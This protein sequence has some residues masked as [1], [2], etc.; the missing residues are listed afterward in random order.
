MEFNNSM[1][2]DSNVGSEENNIQS[3]Q[4]ID[5][6]NSHEFDSIMQLENMMQLESI[7]FDNNRDSDD[8]VESDRSRVSASPYPNY[9]API[10]FLQSHISKVLKDAGV[11]C[12]LWDE[13]AFAIYCL[14]Q[15]TAKTLSWVIPD[16]YIHDA[17]A[18]LLLAKFQYPLELFYDDFVMVPDY[19]LEIPRKME[20][21][22]RPE[23]LLYQKTR[24]CWS[25]PDPPMGRPGRNATYYTLT[26]DTRFYS[27]YD[28][29]DRDIKEDRPIVIVDK[30]DPFL[31]Q[32]DPGTHIP[33]DVEEL[34]FP[35]LIDR[36]FRRRYNTDKHFKDAYLAK[37]FWY[38]RL[39]PDNSPNM[40][41][42][43][44]H[45][46]ILKPERC[47]EAILLL[48]LRNYGYLNSAVD[49]DAKIERVV[50]LCLETDKPPYLRLDQIQEPFREYFSRM[51]DP[52]YV[53]V[54]TEGGICQDVVYLRA[55]HQ[56]LRATAQL[57]PP[58]DDPFPRASVEPMMTG[59]LDAIFQR[60]KISPGLDIDPPEDSRSAEGL[61]SPQD[62]TLPDADDEEEEGQGEEEEEAEEE[63]G[64]TD[65]FDAN[66]CLPHDKL[67][68]LLNTDRVKAKI[69]ANEKQWRIGRNF[70]SR[71]V[72]DAE[73]D[74]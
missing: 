67:V 31:R 58:G 10:S 26:S 43:P 20:L 41:Y 52:D 4:N 65:I 14:G 30:Q 63:G 57:P 16:A 39:A 27:P 46:T 44:V 34:R 55:L 9:S 35:H 1:Q 23:I 17:A 51:I 40:L 3:D 29:E 13:S 38:A 8:S 12:F 66:Q 33:I 59:D 68:D 73:S 47:L 25:F 37:P 36:S 54:I 45:V 21:D 7:E 69:A 49:W 61:A 2:S 28:P 5:F 53:F 24:V 18:A 62:S 32:V 56:V 72:S 71:S 60:L 50:R 42:P 22:K 48:L 15:P 64:E 70:Y 74:L 11:P 19:H 6:D